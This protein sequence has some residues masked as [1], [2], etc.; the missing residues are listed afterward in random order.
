MESSQLHVS[1]W[2]LHHVSDILKPGKSNFTSR[3]HVSA[4]ILL[5]QEASQSGRVDRPGSAQL[6]LEGL[7]VWRDKKRWKEET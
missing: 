2:T 3:L 4:Q 5:T 1:W 7:Q 6:V